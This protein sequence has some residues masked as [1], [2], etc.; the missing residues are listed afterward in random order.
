METSAF[1]GRTKRLFH[2][3]SI[4]TIHAIERAFNVV[5]SYLACSSC[6][7]SCANRHST[8]PEGVL[9]LPRREL[10]SRSLPQRSFAITNNCY[11][12]FADEVDVIG[13]TSNQSDS[14]SL[15]S[16]H[17][18]D[19]GVGVSR[20]RRARA[21]SPPSQPAARPRRATRV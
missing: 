13:Y 5:N 20:A 19:S 14:E 6:Q 21:R 10:R 2:I 15:V 16:G 12:F 9:C 1:S 3:I 17:S 11:V 4:A 7:P 8:W 18:G